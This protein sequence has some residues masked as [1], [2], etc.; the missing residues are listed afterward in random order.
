[1]KTLIN[2]NE[3]FEEKR[4]LIAKEFLEND[5]LIIHIA[6][7]PYYDE[8][9]FG[10]F[11]ENSPPMPFVV[12]PWSCYDMGTNIVVEFKD[13][14]ENK[15]FY[16]EN[17]L[18]TIQLKLT[19]NNLS[20]SFSIEQDGKSI[21]SGNFVSHQTARNSCIFGQGFRQRKWYGLISKICIESYKGVFQKQ[22]EIDRNK[23]ISAFHFK[24][25]HDF[26]YSN[27]I[28]SASTG[29]I[30]TKRSPSKKVSLIIPIYNVEKY[31]REC[32]DSALRQSFLP[33]EYEV[34]LVND[35]STDSSGRIA[36]EYSN[37]YEHFYLVTHQENLG[38]GPARNS[39]LDKSQGEFVFFLDGDDR[40][41]PQCLQNLYI[42][43]KKELSDIVIC[44]YHKVDENGSIL[45]TRS[46]YL[47]I[48]PARM[49][50]LKQIFRYDLSPMCCSM[51]IRKKLF[52]HNNITF[53]PKLHEDTHV[54]YKLY[55]NAVKVSLHHANYYNW[56][57]RPG[58]IT[59]KITLQHIKDWTDGLIGRK[60]WLTE[61]IGQ[62]GLLEFIA[63][64]NFGMS[65]AINATILDRIEKLD[66]EI[67]R[68]ALKN[69][70][71]K[72]IEESETLKGLNISQ[73][74]NIKQLLESSNKSL[75]H[76]SSK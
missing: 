60:K 31:I 13:E 2:S 63:D 14:S 19:V 64:L 41:S 43:A 4:G 15:K 68:S 65:K 69:Y 24:K 37:R 62:A 9:S 76:G 55:F 74:P 20:N 70:V 18:E 40:I 59:S 66:S 52:T 29:E 36:K 38:L 26:H 44:G 10:G 34:I 45:A 46:A 51:L 54:S 32:L 7:T 47:N 16:L 61:K 56:L 50:M 8:R 71:L 1:M 39:G 30:D 58:S 3:V 49:E 75:I 28:E 6:I 72:V 23:L 25:T 48:K 27:L 57:T 35:A 21:H 22:I 5:I 53:P 42:K 12:G 73:F 67:E 11:S 17:K 33:D